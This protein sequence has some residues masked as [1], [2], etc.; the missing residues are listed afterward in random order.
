MN[1]DVT[2]RVVGLRR[3]SLAGGVALAL[4]LVPVGPA[5][6]ATP[7]P[8]KPAIAAASVVAAELSP[9]TPPATPGE[10]WPMTTAEMQGYGCLVA[11]GVTLALTALSGPNEVVLIFT[12]GSVTP[13]TSFG[14]AIAGPGT[15]VAS[16][17]AVG[18]LATPAVVRAWRYY[19][20]GMRLATTP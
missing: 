13:T 2:L 17:C 20:D 11:G 10:L 6:H 15:I 8:L 18:A 7:P 5:V 3:R 9:I 1:G 19:Y 12:G 16:L 4:A 14:L